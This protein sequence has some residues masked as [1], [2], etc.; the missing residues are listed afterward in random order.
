MAVGIK[1]GGEIVV[2]HEGCVLETRE[3][4]GYHDSDFYAIVWDDAAGAVRTVEYATTRG[5]TYDNYARVDATDEVKAKAAAYYAAE[6]VKRARRVAAKEAL[7]IEKGREVVVTRTIRSRKL[8][9]AVEKGETGVV[10]A[11][12][13]E[14]GN[15]YAEKY[16]RHVAKRYRVALDAGGELWIGERDLKVT[17]AEVLATLDGWSKAATRERAEAHARHTV[18]DGKGTMAGMFDVGWIVF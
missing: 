2:T 7:A 15:T 10:K 12:A 14:F 11:E 5:W 18:I 4:N 1:H 6:M 13:R 16:G 8:G 17:L 3:R 9:R